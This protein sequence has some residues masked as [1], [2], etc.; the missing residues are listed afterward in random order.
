MSAGVLFAMSLALLTSGDGRSPATMLLPGFHLSPWFGEQVREQWIEGDV[1][2]LVNAAS[3]FDHS[4]PTRLVVFATPNGNTIEQTLGCGPAEG[5]DWH[6]DIQHVAAQV[7]RLREVVAKENIVLACVQAEGLSWPAWR[8]AHGDSTVRAQRVVNWVKQLLPDTKIRVTLTGHSG[9][10]SFI[11]SNIDAGNAIASDV[12]RIA[13]LDAN[14][15]YSDDAKH[16]E[17]LM[18]WLGV[19][20]AR[21][22][23]VIA[24]DDR[25]IV[26]DG[27][28]VVGPTGGTYRAT[29]RM[30]ERFRKETRVAE[31]KAGDFTTYLGFDSQFVAHVHA[32]PNNKILHTVLVGEMNGLLE[33][34]TDG[35]SGWGQFGGPRAYAKLIQPAPGIPSRPAEAPGGAAFMRSIAGLSRDAREDAIAAELSRGNVPAFLRKFR[36]VTATIKDAAGKEHSGTY[37]VMP[38]Y[39]AVGSDDDFVRVPMSPLTAQRIADAFGCAMSTRKIADD[40]YKQAAVKLAPIPLTKDREAVDTFVEHNRLIEEQRAGKQ[41]GLLVAGIKKDVVVTN[42]LGEKPNRVAIYGWHKPDGTPIQPLTIVHVN[43][44]V[45]YSHGIRLMKRTIAVDGKLRD[46]HSVMH[47]AELCGLLGDEGP[48]QF[49]SY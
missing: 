31:T 9:G 34:L 37:E 49:P 33:A 43:W 32:N 1:R 6:F 18:A 41:L 44:Y 47:S 14:Y 30:L 5:L 24:Y 45:D 27:K 38:D 36:P 20:K 21:R 48:I 28:K 29:G 22:L 13:F 10:G 25:E 40:V 12:E 11:F 26:L 46:V 7:R 23:V 3:D 19:D 35:D 2:I 17:R 42:R 8:K 15:S 16:G 39:L 4:R